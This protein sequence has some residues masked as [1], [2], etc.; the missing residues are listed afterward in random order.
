MQKAMVLADSQEIRELKETAKWGMDREKK[1]AILA[2][3]RYGNEGFSAIQEVLDL[4]VYPE[5]KQ[6][7]IE[8]IRSVGSTRAKGKQ[9]KTP[10]GR[11]RS[12]RKAMKA[13]KTKKGNTRRG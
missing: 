8:A 2:L 7:C 11:T 4:T 1:R 13:K 6:A 5:I 10:S 9:S 3:S 12:N